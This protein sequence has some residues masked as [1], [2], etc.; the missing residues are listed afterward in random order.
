MVSAVCLSIFLFLGTFFLKP[1]VRSCVFAYR[2]LVILVK[3]YQQFWQ[4]G[5]GGGGG[6]GGFSKT[7]MNSYI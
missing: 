1:C 4:G 5:G 2:E 7:L 6:G 3:N